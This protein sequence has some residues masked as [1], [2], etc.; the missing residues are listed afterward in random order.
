MKLTKNTIKKIIREELAQEG[1][2][3]MFKKKAAA[4][5]PADK[6][7]QVKAVLDKFRKADDV[8]S[9]DFGILDDIHKLGITDEIGDEGSTEKALWDAISNYY[10]V[11]MDIIDLMNK[12]IEE[13]TW[14]NSHLNPYNPGEQ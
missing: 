12:S 8:I 5:A 10:R 3:D 13:K 11:T 1:I 6:A 2:M 4:P 7:A 9:G 14:K